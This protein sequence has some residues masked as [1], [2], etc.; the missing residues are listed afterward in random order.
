MPHCFVESLQVV[1][2]PANLYRGW[3]TILRRMNGELVAAC[4]GGRAGHVCPFGRVEVIRSTD[5][6]R[7][8]DK[9]RIIH[10]SI[11]D[12][13]DAGL[14][15]TSKG[16]LLV[17]WF[18][19]M[20]WLR[21]LEKNA[22]T[23]RDDQGCWAEGRLAQWERVRAAATDEVVARE[24]GVW[25]VRSEDGGQ[26]WSKPIDTC[27]NSPHGPTLLRG[28]SLLYVGKDLWRGGRN[29]ASRSDDDG[30]T[31]T[32][33]G[34]IPTVP[35]DNFADYHEFHAV[36]AT[37]G[38]IIAQIRS[39]APSSHYQTLQCESHDE[40]RT[41]T[42]PHT[43]GVWGYPSHLLRLADGRL[44]MTYGHRR[45]PYSIQVRVS[46]DHGATWSEPAI[47]A[48]TFGTDMGYP[49][50]A[51]LADGT[52]VSLWYEKPPAYP[53]GHTDAHGW[54][55]PLSRT[56]ASVLKVARWQLG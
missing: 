49:S 32:V 39:H 4:S 29:L 7:T 5:G 54:C 6:G 37:D 45:D 35:G 26:T 50:T 23:P 52:L 9:P 42:I 12:D 2:D 1:A 41:W 43:I 51:E 19:S 30:R 14:L 38:R 8:W 15:E 24:L 31:W 55:D 48:T 25:A 22:S 21:I 20:A 40:G 46:E 10:K 34:D 28:G 44:L 33:A 17:T 11:I 13:R 56:K 47:I 3:P 18:T 27:V 36:Q 53:Q 16:T